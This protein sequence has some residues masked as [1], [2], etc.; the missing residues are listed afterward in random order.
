MNQQGT[1]K[2][3]DD[4]R[5]MIQQ[6]NDI[7]FGRNITDSARDGDDRPLPTHSKSQTVTCWNIGISS[8]MIKPA[9]KRCKKKQFSMWRAWTSLSKCHNRSSLHSDGW[10]LWR[11]R[12]YTGQDLDWGL[13]PQIQSRQHQDIIE[14]QTNKKYIMKS[15]MDDPLISLNR[16]T[17]W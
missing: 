12:Q 2:S 11:A 15:P 13:L 1:E 4:T 3:E 10:T 17:V 6:K 16:N 8:I 7:T 5:N 9:W 14:K